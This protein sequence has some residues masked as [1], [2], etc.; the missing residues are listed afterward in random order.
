MSEI[1]ENDAKEIWWDEQNDTWMLSI[2]PAKTAEVK[3]DKKGEVQHLTRNGSHYRPLHLIQEEDQLNPT[4]RSASQ[5]LTMLKTTKD[6]VAVWKLIA[7]S[8]NHLE[9]FLKALMRVEVLVKATSDELVCFFTTTRSP[10][11]YVT[12]TQLNRVPHPCRHDLTQIR[13]RDT[14]QIRQKSPDTVVGE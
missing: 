14:G 6:D 3:W 11:A 12:R 4:I 8:I 5:V 9:A 2:I 1:I 7:S 10:L 13:T